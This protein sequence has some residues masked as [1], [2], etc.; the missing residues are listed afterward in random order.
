MINN[1]PLANSRSIHL[2]VGFP[3]LL[4]SS[5]WTCIRSTANAG[6][7]DKAPTPFFYAQQPFTNPHHHTLHN[8]T[9]QTQRC[10]QFHHMNYFS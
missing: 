8:T 9:S 3:S 1:A 6:L 10:H 7:P 5:F 2:V 4:R